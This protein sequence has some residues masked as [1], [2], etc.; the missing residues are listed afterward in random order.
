MQLNSYISKVILLAQLRSVWSI[1]WATWSS[2][3][4]A[5]RVSKF[6]LHT[7]L[8]SMLKL[9]H[10]L[11]TAH[12]ASRDWMGHRTWASSS[13]HHLSCQIS[14]FQ[15]EMGTG[16]LGNVSHHHMDLNMILPYARI[17][18]RDSCR[19]TRPILKISGWMAQ[20]LPGNFLSAGR[21]EPERIGGVP[22]NLC[23][24]APLMKTITKKVRQII[25]G[26][27]SVSFRKTASSAE[28]HR[29]WPCTM[30][31]IQI[32]AIYTSIMPA[33]KD[34]IWPGRYV[35]GHSISNDLKRLKLEHPKE[36]LVDTQLDDNLPAG[37]PTTKRSLRSIFHAVYKIHIQSGQKPHSAK[38]AIMPFQACPL[39]Y[40]IT[41]HKSRSNLMT[42]S[43][44]VLPA[45]I[46][47]RCYDPNNTWSCIDLFIWNIA[48]RC[49]CDGIAFMPVINTQSRWRFQLQL[50]GDVER[51]WQE[52]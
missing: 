11:A 26:V 21:G 34:M 6:I 32:S 45:F 50:L 17:T 33:S 31:H 29:R 2:T 25:Q 28:R 16:S 27:Q 47:C 42:V 52:A 43:Q 48:Y 9:P 3:A 35:I 15:I 51:T 1:G 44:A 24:N 7:K 36:M 20:K 10:G 5:N 41:L 30:S 19:A 12:H 4:I 18:I 40:M 38:C 8:V 23:Q 49:I 46:S 14:R 39:I 13:G 22:S 37:L